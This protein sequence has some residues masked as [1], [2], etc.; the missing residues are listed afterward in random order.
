M[1][2]LKSLLDNLKEKL[3]AGWAEQQ[4]S[5]LYISTKEKFEA[6]PTVAQRA[7]IAGIAFLAVLVVLWWPLSNFIDSV[8]FNSKFD[9][10]RQTL[11]ELLRIERDIANNP[12]VPVPPA[13]SSMKGQFDSKIA[14]AG[15]KPDQ[16]KDQSEMAPQMVAGANQQ[17]FQYRI[18]H[19]TVRQALDLSYELE[20]TDP[21]F[22]LAG[23]ELLAE[24][25][26]PHFYELGIKIVSF[27][28]KI[29]DLGAPGKGIVDS[30]KK[31]RGGGASP[32]KEDKTNVE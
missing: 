31:V 29:A 24:P 2:A 30:I 25:K 32:D 7:I 18:A 26:D 9:E 5:E 17:G 27:A 21:N 13:P 12:N 6:L 16:I 3:K 15:I 28:P 19:L 22:K 10:R 11:K 1:D 20:H 4:E 14:G 8:D 23:L